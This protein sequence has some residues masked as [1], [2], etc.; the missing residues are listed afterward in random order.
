[1]NKFLTIAS[2][3]FMIVMN[4]LANTLPIN[5]KNTGELSDMYPNLFV[6]AGFTFSIWA[7]IYTLVII[8]VVRIVAN[9]DKFDS[10]IPLNF[11]ANGLWIVAWHYLQIEL[12]LLI[13]LFLLFSLVMINLR[14]EGFSKLTY[15][16]Y[17]GWICV[18][19]VANVT[20]I[21]VTYDF[22]FLLSP[23]VWT[24]VLIIVAGLVGCFTALRL[25][26][27]FVL[28]PIFWALYGI[29]AKRSADAEPIVLIY[30]CLLATA[31]LMLGFL[32]QN[33]KKVLSF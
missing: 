23:A 18:A 25:R 30:Y 32:V 15:G 24:G 31:I 28:A 10:W 22:N 11:I 3:V 9:K 29:Y 16:V 1:M 5:G 6:P 27:V 19:T 33:R 7:V 12:S 13:M 4:T 21:L 17:L 14:N 2:F 8:S 26:N 20:T